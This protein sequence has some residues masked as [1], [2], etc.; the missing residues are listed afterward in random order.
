MKLELNEKMS[1][2]D[3]LLNRHF[4]STAI[5]DLIDG[6]AERLPIS[7]GQVQRILAALRIQDHEHT[8]AEIDNAVLRT[9][10]LCL[11]IDLARQ[12]ICRGDIEVDAPSKELL[13]LLCLL[14]RQRE[15]FIPV[16]SIQAALGIDEK[17]AV[18]K[19]VSRLNEYLRLAGLG[20]KAR[21]KREFGYR[22][23]PTPRS[24]DC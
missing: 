19:A 3:L 22:L 20:I 2:G 18:E 17:G 16:T 11:E 9:G 13:D 10:H 5:S 6:I 15:C 7:L 1:G 24:K 4:F 12:R 14:A 8:V 23:E 21:N